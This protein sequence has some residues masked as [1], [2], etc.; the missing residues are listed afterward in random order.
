MS[1]Q[2]GLSVNMPTDSRKDLTEIDSLITP[3]LLYQ[4]IAKFLPEKAL[5][6]ARRILLL[7]S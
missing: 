1:Y 6:P 5:R 4:G 7:Q 3:A 2:A